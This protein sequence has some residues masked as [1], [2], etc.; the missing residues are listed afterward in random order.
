MPELSDSIHQDFI[1]MHEKIIKQDIDIQILNDF[2]YK[3]FDLNETEIKI[4]E[5]TYNGKINS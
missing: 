4:I 5:E 1:A 2:V 3:L